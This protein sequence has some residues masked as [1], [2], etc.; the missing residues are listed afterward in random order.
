MRV[1]HS[2]LPFDHEQEGAGVGQV[3]NPI[4]QGAVSVVVHMAAGE[5]VKVASGS[6]TE[7]EEMVIIGKLD[8]KAK[9]IQD[10]RCREMVKAHEGENLRFDACG[11]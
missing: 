11:Q 5:A 3:I 7:L 6:S 2:E 10:S 1:F 9:D 4:H 8:D